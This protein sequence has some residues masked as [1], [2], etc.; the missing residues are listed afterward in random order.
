ML[1]VSSAAAASGSKSTAIVLLL[2]AMLSF[3]AGAS[4]AKHLFATIG[5]PATTALR[6]T[7]SALVIVVLQQP[8]RTLPSRQAWPVILVYGIALGTMNF[9]FYMAL[10]TVPLGI[11]VALEFMGPLAVSLAAS[12]HRS[13]V[14]WVALAAVGVLLLLPV[15]PLGSTV[16]PVGVLFALAAGACW[17][18]YIVFG[19]RAGQAHGTAASAWGMLTAALV[20]APVGFSLGDSG[21]LAPRSLALG[22]VVAVLSSAFPYTLEMVALRR[23]TTRAFGTLM[24]LDPALA[25]L[26]G[27][28]LLR[29]QLTITQ[30]LAVISITMASIGIMRSEQRQ[31]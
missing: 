10:R 25:A 24:S 6:L 17:A 13:D 18:T 5:A 23:L 11:A 29:E 7:L 14:L 8:W 12:R 20:V 15:T 27:W 19:K 30:W 4:V 22:F 1:V 9:V 21:A 16:D 31:D 28:A 2:V 26:A 3:Q